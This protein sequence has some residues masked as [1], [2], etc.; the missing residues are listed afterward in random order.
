MQPTARMPTA[1]FFDLRPTPMVIRLL[2]ANGVLWFVFSVLVNFA[3]QGWA[4]TL[5][6]DYLALR[7]ADVVPGLQLWEAATYMWL[8]DLGSPWHLLMNM[9]GLFFLGVPLERRWGSR[10]F[11]RFY[12]LAALGAG[13]FTVI[14]GLLLPGLFGAPVVGAS[15]G[16]IA[17]LAAFSMIVPEATILLFFVVPVRARYVIWI[18]LGIDTALFLSQPSGGIAYHTHVGG[19]LAAWLLI[20]GNWRPRLAAS[21]LRL[22]LHRLRAGRRARRKGLRVIPGGRGDRMLN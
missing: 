7:P 15:G 14:V 3:Q 21:R 20:T 8:H 18:A 22:L 2:I 12:L 17:L 1:G 4:A 9:L 13:V 5:F 16:V 6:L 19:A 11:L 10:V